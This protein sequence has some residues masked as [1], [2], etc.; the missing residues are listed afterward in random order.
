ML[1]RSHDDQLV[2]ILKQRISMALQIGNAA[3]VLGT[4]SDRE[5][6]EEIFHIQL[7]FLKPLYHCSFK[8]KF[9]RSTEIVT[10]MSILLVVPFCYWSTGIVSCMGFPTFVADHGCVSSP[11]NMMIHMAFDW[12]RQSMISDRGKKIPKTKIKRIRPVI[13][14]RS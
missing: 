1:C 13:Y 3:C 7:L 10:G 4:V 5:A 12:W 14:F 8:R 11:P 2:G 9:Y 6:F